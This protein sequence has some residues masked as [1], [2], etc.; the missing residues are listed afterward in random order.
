MFSNGDEGTPGV[1]GTSCGVRL[2]FRSL[3]SY[4]VN[5]HEPQFP[6]L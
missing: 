3:L 1:E 4:D 2:K 5:I 6:H